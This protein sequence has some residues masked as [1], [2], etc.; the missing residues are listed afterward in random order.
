METDKTKDQM[1]KDDNTESKDIKDDDQMNENKKDD[2][3]SKD[4]KDEVNNEG[5]KNEVK[6]NEELIIWE[7]QL[8]TLSGKL[9]QKQMELERKEILIKRHEK[10]LAVSEVQLQ[11]KIEEFD[12]MQ[13]FYKLVSGETF[14]NLEITSN[15]ELIEIVC[16]DEEV[17]EEVN[18]PQKFSSL[19]DFPTQQQ[20]SNQY[21]NENM[22]DLMDLLTNNSNYTSDISESIQTNITTNLSFSMSTIHDT[23]NVVDNVNEQNKEKE[24][25][26]PFK[27]F[28]NENI[29]T[30]DTSI[31]S[32]QHIPIPVT[33][34]TNQQKDIKSTNVNDLEFEELN[35]PTST[36]PNS[37]EPK[38][39]VF[40][41]ENQEQIAK[42]SKDDFWN[43]GKRSF[44][45]KQTNQ[46][47]VM[48]ASTRNF[49]GDKFQRFKEPKKV[50]VKDLV[51]MQ[52][53]PNQAI[54][55]S[56]HSKKKSRY[57]IMGQPICAHPNCNKTTS[58]KPEDFHVC[59]V[60][61]TAY[62][63]DHQDGVEIVIP[64]FKNQTSTKQ[65]IKPFSICKECK[66]ERPFLNAKQEIGIIS[67][68][69]NDFALR[70]GSVLDKMK[71]D[72][73]IVETGIAQLVAR[74]QKGKFFKKKETA[75]ND[76]CPVCDALMNGGN[77]MK[78]V[79]EICVR[80]CC[81]GCSIHTTIA[82][83]LI[84][85]IQ[86]PQA[87][88]VRVVLC[89]KC[90]NCTQKKTKATLHESQKDDKLLD[91][92]F[93]KYKEHTETLQRL[94]Y[95]LDEVV[96]SFKHKEDIMLFE[97]TENG[98]TNALNQVTQNISQLKKIE[99]TAQKDYK[100]VI[101]N[102]ILAFSEVIQSNSLKHAQIF[103]RY[104]A[105]VKQLN[106]K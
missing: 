2:V 28:H 53:N 24:T 79:C 4:Q 17:C 75:H 18:T 67:N 102:L 57:S 52:S 84:M 94:N 50:D 31:S 99:E 42:S 14:D 91:D 105:K 21:L 16:S 8:L 10:R 72:E 76:D 12:E 59:V 97:Q 104:T 40:S 9:E 82:P 6:S 41:N 61:K 63:D 103:Q 86:D 26:A 36:D 47:V 48:F 96:D 23:N 55:D 69:W 5:Q 81:I 54:N 27:D 51:T 101:T 45:E 39:Y 90:Y 43:E 71:I 33:V 100:K 62:C 22:P 92:M 78:T 89:K 37:Y 34:D 3:I 93:N 58:P 56:R 98:Y 30:E 15:G 60:C 7:Q 20:P 85:G 44:G 29:N 74:K 19:I 95:E 65:V 68:A 73:K 77:K 49:N 32:S 87:E 64:P 11:Q 38:E 88:Y 66:L 25:V 70:R 1:E 83:T 46:N 106:L 80:N 35:L 13:N